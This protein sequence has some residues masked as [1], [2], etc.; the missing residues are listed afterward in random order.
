MFFGR[1]TGWIL[2]AIAIVMAS[3][4]VVLALGLKTHAGIAT[5]EVLTLL[6][7][8][9]PAT[10]AAPS[11]FAAAEHLLMRLPAWVVIGALG[12]GLLLICRRRRRHFI[13]SRR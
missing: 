13:F 3:A 6:T 4:D 10:G 1:L 8:G 7:G 11:P 12:T 5:G 9:V 2:V